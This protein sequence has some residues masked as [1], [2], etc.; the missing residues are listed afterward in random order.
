MMT[1][2]NEAFVRSVD[3]LAPDGKTGRTASLEGTSGE[4]QP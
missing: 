3:P 1:L 2:V 4:Q